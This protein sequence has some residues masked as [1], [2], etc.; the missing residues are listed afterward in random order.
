MKQDK[1]RVRKKEREKGEKT[2]ID[3][4][5]EGKLAYITFIS[6]KIKVENEFILFSK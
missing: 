5:I 4:G 1:T 2:L 3:T 6:A